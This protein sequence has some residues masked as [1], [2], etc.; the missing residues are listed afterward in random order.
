MATVGP[1]MTENSVLVDNPREM[2][3]TNKKQYGINF[4]FPGRNMIAAHSTL[5]F[6]DLLWARTHF[7]SSLTVEQM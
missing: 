5:F 7:L 3:Q 2:D 6:T 1:Q 4:N